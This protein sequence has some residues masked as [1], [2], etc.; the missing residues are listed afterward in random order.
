M[1]GSESSST[2]PVAHGVHTTATDG[3]KNPTSQSEQGVAESES[4]SA[5]PLAQGVQEVAPPDS[6]VS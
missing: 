5:V 2:V 3:E 1:D 6:D 4:R